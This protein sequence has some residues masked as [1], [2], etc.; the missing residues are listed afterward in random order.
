MPLLNIKTYPLMVLLSLF[1]LSLHAQYIYEGSFGSDGAGNG[2]FASPHGIC[3]D[4]SDNIYVCD[5]YTGGNDRIQKFN[6]SGIF[7]STIGAGQLY[8]PLGVAVDASGNIFVGDGGPRIKKF[9]SSGVYQTYVNVNGSDYLACD[10]TGN[11]YCSGTYVIEK[12]PNSLSSMTLEF[13]SLGTG[14]GEFDNP[15][16]AGLC[17]DNNGYIFAVDSKNNRVQKFT[18]SG[19]YLSQFGSFGNGPGQFDGPALIVVDANNNLYVL[20]YGN[21]R[22]QKFDNAGTYLTEFSTSALENPSGLAVNSAGKIFIPNDYTTNRKVAIFAPA[23]EINV[24]VGGISIPS[25]TSIYD[26]GDINAGN[27]AQATFTIQNTGLTDLQ[28]TLV[29]LVGSSGYSVDPSALS[30]PIGANSTSSFD[31]NF[32]PSVSGPLSATI[33]ISNNDDDESSYTFT[34]TG[35]GVVPSALVTPGSTTDLIKIYPNPSSNGLVN[36]E[37]KEKIKSV[38]FINNLGQKEVVS[39]YENIHTSMKGLVLVII[40]T[41]A[42][43]YSYKLLMQ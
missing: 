16:G 19:V 8:S 10:G 12:F 24:T 28:I 43:S 22:V 1:A 15:F 26:F 5:T 17:I 21:Q 31:I 11:V 2:Q 34:V 14:D 6:S 9:N 35:N 41:D 23:P 4:N 18:S 38:T 42:K 36:I 20:D 27:N 37:S 3:I 40:E 7:Q 25:G 30:S 32:N 13:G 29:E 39:D 33:T